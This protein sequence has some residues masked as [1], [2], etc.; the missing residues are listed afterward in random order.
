MACAGRLWLRAS[1]GDWRL[2]SSPPIGPPRDE[3]YAAAA[4]PS[5]HGGLPAEAMGESGWPL[6][7]APSAKGG[8]GEG[9]GEPGPP[10]LPP[11]H[12]P[13]GGPAQG[14]PGPPPLPP[15]GGPAQGGLP[16]EAPGMA[17]APRHGSCWLCGLCCCS[18][19]DRG[20]DP[21]SSPP[22][23]RPV[24]ATPGPWRLGGPPSPLGDAPLKYGATSGVVGGRPC[25]E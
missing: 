7:H 20:G 2:P 21:P 18:W 5:T 3:K 17:A 15:P 12:P 14:G 16:G 13:P 24:I 9:A 11:P 6:P 8:G 25:G 23:G 19:C 4:A 22:K 1:G 10:P